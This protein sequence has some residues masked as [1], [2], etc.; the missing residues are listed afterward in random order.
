MTH[1]EYCINHQKIRALV[2]ATT[3]DKDFKVEMNL[4]EECHKEFLEN[5]LKFSGVTC[6]HVWFKY[7]GDRCPRCGDVPAEQR[8]WNIRE[9]KNQVTSP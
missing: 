9:I 2:V 6:H 4:C 5:R 1:Q 3:A 8:D 7:E